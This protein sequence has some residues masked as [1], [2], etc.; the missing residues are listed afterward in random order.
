MTSAQLALIFGPLLVF[1]LAMG[2]LTRNDPITTKAVNEAR[3]NPFIRFQTI[4]GCI[5][6]PI[7][8]LLVIDNLFGASLLIIIGLAFLFQEKL[9]LK[10]SFIQGAEAKV[11]GAIYLLIGFILALNT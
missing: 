10:T 7:A 11:F 1:A 8:I 3:K 2:Y 4:I 5:S 9:F 6:C